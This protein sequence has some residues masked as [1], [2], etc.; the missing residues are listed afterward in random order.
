MNQDPIATL[1]ETEDNIITTFE[2]SPLGELMKVK[3]SE[4]IIFQF[5]MSEDSSRLACLLR[6]T[7][8][9][10]VLQVMISTSIY[11]A[12][13]KRGIGAKFIMESSVA[14]GRERNL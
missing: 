5:Q 4:Y 1:Q 3:V 9:R 10:S 14:K 8:I 11:Y 2:R 6:R 12:L 13:V 7:K